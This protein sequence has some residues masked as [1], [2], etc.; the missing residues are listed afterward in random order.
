MDTLKAAAPVLGPTHPPVR[1]VRPMFVSTNLMGK[2]DASLWLIEVSGITVSVVCCVPAARA[3]P[4]VTSKEL[5]SASEKTTRVTVPKTLPNLTV[6]AEGASTLLLSFAS[7]WACTTLSTTRVRVP[8]PSIGNSKL[9]GATLL[10]HL[11]LLDTQFAPALHS[12]HQRALTTSGE[13]TKNVKP[14]EEEMVLR[15]YVT[16]ISPH[17]G[18]AGAPTYLTKMFWVPAAVTAGMV[19]RIWTPPS[20]FEKE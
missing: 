14:V 2:R 8:V 3:L 1:H 16:P 4:S 15:V 18:G 5:R 6:T 10:A 9:R 13:G 17:E 19:A 12:L 11:P 20:T 7:N